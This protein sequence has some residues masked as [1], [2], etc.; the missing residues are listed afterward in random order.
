[1][2]AELFTDNTILPGCHKLFWINELNDNS[3]FQ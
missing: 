2:D 1:V 3:K